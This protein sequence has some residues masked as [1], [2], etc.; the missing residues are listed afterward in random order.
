MKILF[1]SHALV[2][3]LRGDRR[4]SPRVR[5]LANAEDVDAFV[6][7]V[8]AWEIAT[9]VGR[10]KWP[11]AADIARSIE[12][13]TVTMEFTPLPIT[14]KHAQVAGFLPSRHRD[15]FDRMLAAQSQVE[16]IA[17]ATADP[18]FGDFGVQVI[19]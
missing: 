11:E 19:W 1:D 18:V 6:S 10:G 16:A 8:C 4:L 12:Q 3:Y 2:W 13:I 7:A 9:K 5:E 15:P 17:L 14:I